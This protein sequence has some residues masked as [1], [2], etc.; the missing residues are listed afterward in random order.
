MSKANLERL[1]RLS[2]VLYGFSIA[3]IV[4]LIGAGFYVGWL[5]LN[6][7]AALTG[8]FPDAV[9]DPALISMPAR[10]GTI[11]LGWVTLGLTIHAVASLMRMFALFAKGQVFDP[12]AARWMRRAGLSLFALAIYSMVARTATILLLSLANPP[13]QR[14]LAIGIESTQLLSVFVAGV[15]MLVAHALVLGSEI[16]QEN[17]GFV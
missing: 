5:A 4:I 2:R 7:P 16:E 14:Q 11:A 1:Q 8:N 9:R 15:F 6:D 13:G 3:L 12:A 10:I 17:R